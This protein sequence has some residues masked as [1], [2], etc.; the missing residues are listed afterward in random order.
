LGSRQLEVNGLN[1]AAEFD[2]DM[3][4]SPRLFI[5]MAIAAELAEN[6]DQRHSSVLRTLLWW[7]P[8]LF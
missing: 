4:G 1:A 3:A 5:F 6:S 8:F 2:K 7:K